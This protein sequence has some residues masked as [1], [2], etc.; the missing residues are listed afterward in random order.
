MLA[1]TSTP[2][3]LIH[4]KFFIASSICEFSNESK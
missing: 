1:V 2:L 3:F 4:N